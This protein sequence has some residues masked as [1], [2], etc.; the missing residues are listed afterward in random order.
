MFNDLRGIK[1]LTCD[2]PVIF[3]TLSL[4]A[5]KLNYTF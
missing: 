3:A 4:K 1:E 5:K 2:Q